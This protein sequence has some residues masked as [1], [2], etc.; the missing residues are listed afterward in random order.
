MLP[1]A[2]PPNAVV[3]SSGE[4]RVSDMARRGFALKRDPRSDWVTAELAVGAD[5]PRPA[6]APTEVAGR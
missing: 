4:L 5:A 1:V 3:F 2:T 6:A